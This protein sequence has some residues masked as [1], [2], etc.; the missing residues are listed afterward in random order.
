M[1]IE[2]NGPDAARAMAVLL[3]PHPHYGGNRFHPFIDGLFQLLPDVGIGVVRFDFSSAVPAEAE[4]EVLAAID[5]GQ[6][7]WPGVP[8]VLVGYSFGAGVAARVDDS[9]ISAWY[10]LAPPVTM[11]GDAAIGADSRPK[12]IVVP[13]HDHSSPPDVVHDAVSTWTA[14]TLSTADGCDHFLGAAVTGIVRDAVDSVAALT[15]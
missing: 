11:L 14:V 7:A 9:R 15:H 6:A 3:H 10:L 13:A 5:N 2:R 12:T 8:T 1:I 4:G